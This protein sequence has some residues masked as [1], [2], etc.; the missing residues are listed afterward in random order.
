MKNSFRSKFIILLLCAVIILSMPIYTLADDSEVIQRSYGQCPE[1]GAHAFMDDT[2]G[3][4]EEPHPHLTSVTCI[5]CDAQA[6][7]MAVKT[8]CSS[9]RSGAETVVEEESTSDTLQYVD[10]DLGIGTVIFV[11]TTLYV[12]HTNTY[13]HISTIYANVYYPEFASFAELVHAE[14]EANH[15]ANIPC[16]ETTAN[17]ELKYYDDNDNLIYTQQLSF[18][19]GYDAMG[20]GVVLSTSPAYVVA[21]ASCNLAGNPSFFNGTVTVDL[22]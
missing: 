6:T 9:C 20:N 19:P 14:A 17:T 3:F 2:P 11:P 13:K 4:P 5:K 7:L 16:L 10:G 12:E 18:L 15:T 21:R 22:P 1:G 8:S